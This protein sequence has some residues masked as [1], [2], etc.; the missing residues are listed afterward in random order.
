[1]LEQDPTIKQRF[2]HILV[3]HPGDEEMV[4]VLQN[5]AE[6]LE[7]HSGVLF[8]Y[9]SLK[10]VIRAVMDHFSDPVMPDNAI[11]I[12]VELPAHVI[13]KH[14]IL[15]EKQDILD[16]VEKKTGVPLGQIKEAE[17]E[18][19]LNVEDLLHKRVI[20]QDEA[21]V[22]VSNAMRRSRAGVRNTRRPI[23][24]FL[25]VGPTGVGKTE[26][27]KA[28]AALFFGDEKNMTRLDMSEFAGGD[29]VARLIGSFDG[30]QIG[31]L[32]RT[33]REH[34]YGVV[35]LDEFEKSATQV[36]DLFLQILDEGFFSDVKGKRVNAR[37]VIFIA[38]S[39]A[40]SNLIFEKMQQE[41]DTKNIQKE[42]VD[43]II[44]E[45]IF[46]PEF[47]NRFDAVVLFHPLELEHIRKISGI[48]LEKLRLRLR[49][50]GLDMEITSEMVEYVAQQGVDPVFG[51]R[52]MNRYIQENLEQV[53]AEKLIRGDIKEGSKFTLLPEDLT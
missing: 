12:L 42:I 21:I 16:I 13:R 34:S 37:N 17:R 3:E 52:P 46:K 20:G 5:V 32:T 28:L 29:A 6:E 25:F 22:V 9:N 36:H 7:K 53:I 14:K 10:T 30:G 41:V 43:H 33:L 8:T 19:L 15:V 48:M 4:E 31:V 51:A 11:D 40:G 35:L 38:T 45:R 27:A 24:S 50:R 39:N 18:T 47:L 44:K 2:E 23:G 49:N 26:T 1:M